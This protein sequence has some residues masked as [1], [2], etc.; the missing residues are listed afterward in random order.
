MIE[1]SRMSGTS[2][3][4]VRPGASSAAAISLSALFFA[5]VTLTRPDRDAPPDTSKHSTRPPYGGA[6]ERSVRRLRLL[7]MTVRLTRIY[8]KTGDAGQTHLGDM[9]RVSK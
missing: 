2:S 9:S 5:P 1:T 8:T 3:M 6:R 4:E 7:G